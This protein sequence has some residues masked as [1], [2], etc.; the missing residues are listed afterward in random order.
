MVLNRTHDFVICINHRYFYIVLQ[1]MKIFQ[2]IIYTH[3]FEIAV[4]NAFLVFNVLI[5]K[6][7]LGVLIV[8]KVIFQCI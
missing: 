3:Y 2:N 8:L 7:I 4:V 6:H 1:F 5:K